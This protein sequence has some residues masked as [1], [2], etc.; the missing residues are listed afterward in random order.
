MYIVHC[1]N[2]QPY[3]TQDKC[4]GDDT[5]TIECSDCD[6]IESVSGTI[7]SPKYPGKYPNHVKKFYPLEVSP[8]FAIELTFTSIDIEKSNE[9]SGKYCHCD[10]VKVYDSD[11]IELAIYCGTETPLKWTSIGNKMLVEFCGEF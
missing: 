6:T 7:S 11:N 3:N 5:D 1:T 10:Y 8:G 2:P 9:C 4:I